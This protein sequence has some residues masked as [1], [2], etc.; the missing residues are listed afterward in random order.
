MIPSTSTIIPPNNPSIYSLPSSMERS[1]S[2]KTLKARPFNSINTPTVSVLTNRMNNNISVSPIPKINQYLRA[3]KSPIRYNIRTIY[4]NQG[5]IL[6]TKISH[7]K[8]GSALY[9]PRSLIQK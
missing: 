8:L 6:Q 3:S 1:V 2:F 7:L 9:K 5:N 4:P